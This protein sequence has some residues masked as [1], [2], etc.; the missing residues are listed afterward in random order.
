MEAEHTA[1]SF[2]RLTESTAS[3]WQ[4]C[5]VPR[6]GVAEPAGGTHRARPALGETGL[7]REFKADDDSP[8]VQV[9]TQLPLPP[10]YFCFQVAGK[11]DFGFQARL[12]WSEVGA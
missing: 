2:L 3:V 6:F 8:V 10:L 7:L 9:V 5:R 11:L 4:P 1:F 12:A